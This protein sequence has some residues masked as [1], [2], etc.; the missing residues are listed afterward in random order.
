VT[1]KLARAVASLE[2]LQQI[3]GSDTIVEVNEQPIKEDDTENNNKNINNDI[4]SSF[5]PPHSRVIPLAFGDFVQQLQRGSTRYYMTTQTLPINDEGQPALFTTPLT[6]LVEQNCMDDLRPR[7]LG[8]LIPMTCNLWIGQTSTT[9]TSGFSS[10]SSGLHHDYHDNLYCLLEGQKTF[11]IA[12]P[13]SVRQLPVKGTL[14]T[15][16]D[17]G[18]I[19]YH[20]QLGLVHDKNSKTKSMTMIRPDGALESVE[21]I[22]ELEIRKEQIEQALANQEKED[23][24]EVNKDE[25][26]EAGGCRIKQ[27][28]SELEDEL[29]EIEEELLDLNMDH[30]ETNSTT[31]DSENSGDDDN[32]EDDDDDNGG[33]LF[34]RGKNNKDI[35][36]N[37]DE[38]KDD[39]DDADSDADCAA[40]H[41]KRV[42]RCSPKG[43]NSDEEY[44]DI[45]I[46]EDNDDDN[47]QEDPKDQEIP[48]NFVMRD[49]HKNID[50]DPAVKFQ[51]IQFYKG[52]LLYLPAGWFHEVYSQGRQG[53]DHGLHIAFNYWMH[54]PD[55]MVG[56]GGVENT[57]NGDTPTST[58]S[59]EQP[60]RSKFWQRDWDSRKES[61]I[62]FKK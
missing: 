45:D 14:H 43:P 8:N 57:S 24:E 10:S 44:E 53:A 12:P 29:N 31:D 20:E 61:K 28:R 19:V 38:D 23:E 1:P 35:R 46:G 51:T 21:R 7:L 15:L 26:I 16:H 25:D 49:A 56:G 60:Y 58:I 32:D 9:A 6:Q 48:L 59:F 34:G 22:M 18:R 13:A 36:A 30:D 5:A 37:E 52:D 39:D 42:K 50:T 40:P 55:V 27:Q 41:P 54:P 11:Q 4:L 47:E 2:H 33:L 62:D 3:I 17:N